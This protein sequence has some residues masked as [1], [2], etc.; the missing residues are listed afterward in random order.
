M[1]V[2]TEAV[3]FT[4]GNPFVDTGQEMMAALAGIDHVSELKKEDVEPL[5]KRLV[6]IYMQEDWR[7]NMHTIFPMSVLASPSFPNP[8][9]PYSALLSKW[10]QLL[11]SDESLEIPCA[12]SGTPAHIYLSKMFLPMSDSVGYNF[13][14]ASQKGTP[15][16]MPITIALQFFPLALTKVG[17]MWG[18]PHFSNDEAQTKWADSIAKN[19]EF[20][21]GTGSSG[22]VDVGT[23]KQVNA[24]FRLIER[25]V[26]DQ[27]N[28]PKSGVTLYVFNNFNKTDH[29][30]TVTDIHYMPSRIF[31]F[32]QAAENHNGGKDWH[33]VV[34]R[35]YPANRKIE[36][37]DDALR[38]FDNS[39]YWNLLHDRSIS[40]FFINWK[41]RCPVVRGRGGWIL[42]RNYLKE[43]R[44]MDQER[45]ENL[46]DL[47]DRIA[48]IVRD[49]KRRLL[50]L[51]GAN[52]RGALTDVLYRIATKDSAGRLNEPLITFDQLVSDLF[53]HDTQYSDWREVKYLLLFR[54]YEQ[55]FDELKDDPEYA[56]TNT[57]DEADEG[58]DSE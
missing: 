28:F 12:I 2:E 16:S 9:Q 18:L 4:T 26:R 51:E 38:R 11:D 24:F 35:G 13:Q 42:Y 20:G 10:F 55:L 45:I 6:S 46:R 21:E 57:G 8:K 1:N 25:L 58:G 50:A 48:P 54:I 17:K 23:S 30:A 5:L 40:R 43:V 7:K 47:G 22:V 31:G 32:I 37:E 33:R 44:G 49:R 29:N 19:I 34:W 52:S 41:E 3:W 56:E 14:S 53:P 36:D 39:V 15:V 27:M